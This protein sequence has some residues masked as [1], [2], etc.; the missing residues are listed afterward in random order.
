MAFGLIDVTVRR[1][2]RSGFQRV[3]LPPG[4]WFPPL[5]AAATSSPDVLKQGA[6][7]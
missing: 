5:G 2:R 6:F 3:Q 7:S 4:N 1:E